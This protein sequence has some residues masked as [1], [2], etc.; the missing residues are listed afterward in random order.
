M[1]IKEKAFTEIE[2]RIESIERAISKNGVGS[3]YLEKAEKIQRDVNI[4][5]MVAGATALLGITAW[6]IIK[7]SDS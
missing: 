7:T 3:K 5:L 4:G 1:N 2:E 6:S